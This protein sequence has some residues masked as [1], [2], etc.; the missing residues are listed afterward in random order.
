[1]VGNPW[2]S[3]PPNTEVPQTKKKNLVA[4]LKNFAVTEARLKSRLYTYVAVTRMATP[5]RD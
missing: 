4:I 1:M 3:Q 5:C 2:A